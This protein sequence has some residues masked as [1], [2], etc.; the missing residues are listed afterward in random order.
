GPALHHHDRPPTSRGQ[1]TTGNHAHHVHILVVRAFGVI[2]I[3]TI[4]TTRRS[5]PDRSCEPP[6]TT[7]SP[8]ACSAAASR[9]R[10]VRAH[11]ARQA[12]APTR[13]TSPTSI[14]A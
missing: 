8:G 2:A 4:C 7:C 11:E 1:P 14:T 12:P 13:A 6:P 3:V 9:P 5:S 10:R